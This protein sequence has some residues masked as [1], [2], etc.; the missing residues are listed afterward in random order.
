[1]NE[2][3]YVYLRF[4]YTCEYTELVSNESLIF[5]FALE[6]FATKIDTF[7]RA[8]TLLLLEKIKTIMTCSRG[9]A[10]RSWKSR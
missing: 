2:D 5:A 8:F 1:M 3:V 4:M 6:Q 10:K 9:T 7:P